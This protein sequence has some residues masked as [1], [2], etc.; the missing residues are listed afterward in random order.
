MSQ[1]GLLVVIS[2]PSGV[3][4]GTVCNEIT[5]LSDKAKISISKTTRKPRRGEVDGINYYFDT[6]ENFENLIK[7]DALLEWAE[8]CGNYYGTPKAE[9]ERLLGSGFNVILEIEVQGAMKVKRKCKDG[10]FIFVMPPSEE[11]LEKRLRGRGTETDEAVSNRLKRALEEIK[12]AKEY[13][14]HV[15]NYEPLQAAKEI[16]DIIEKE[17]K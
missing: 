17:S 14:Y 11:E 10:V 4:K 6:K 1:K 2:G 5:K 9:V 3:G 13:D 16:L 7:N 12:L 8:F 15:I